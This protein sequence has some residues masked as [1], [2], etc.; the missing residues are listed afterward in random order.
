MQEPES[1][2]V[3]VLTAA[4]N[5]SDV[6]WRCL[7]EVSVPAAV[8]RRVMVMFFN[9]S[10]VAALISRLASCRCRSGGYTP[11][12]GSSG[13]EHPARSPHGSICDR[14][15]RMLAGSATVGRW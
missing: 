1:G 14:E 2:Q 11:P 4:G 10:A 3:R 12:P 13:T 7:I 15:G 9:C 8:R 6:K 5:G